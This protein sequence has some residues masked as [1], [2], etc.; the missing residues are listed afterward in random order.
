MFKSNL[1][2]LTLKKAA[3]TGK[4][5]TQKSISFSTG[6]PEP[7]ISNWW[8][9]QIGSRLDGKTVLT[10]CAYLNCEMCELVELIKE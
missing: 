5:I 7:T 9:G 10:F 2:A 8:H 3:A 1:Q 4:S 6:I